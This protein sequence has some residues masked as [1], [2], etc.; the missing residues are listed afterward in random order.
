MDKTRAN[1]TALI[2]KASVRF[3]GPWKEKFR[4]RRL[5]LWDLPGATYFITACLEW[6]I[7]AEGLLDMARYCND[8]AK[9]PQPENMSEND[10]KIHCWKLAF[11]HSDEE[12]DSRPATRRLADKVGHSQGA[13]AGE[14]G[15]TTRAGGRGMKLCARDLLDWLPA[16]LDRKMRDRKCWLAW[17]TFI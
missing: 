9:R 4:R 8:L 17:R 12:L 13:S 1:P 2:A 16:A 15:L 5:P 7:L 11:A 14:A 10:W 6:S 3:T